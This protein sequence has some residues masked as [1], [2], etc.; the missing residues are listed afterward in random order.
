MRLTFGV[1]T[2]SCKHKDMNVAHLNHEQAIIFHVNLP[3]ENVRAE[4]NLT[5]GP[6]RRSPQ[7]T[8]TLHALATACAATGRLLTASTCRGG[9]LLAS[10]RAG[11]LAA[12]CG[13]AQVGCHDRIVAPVVLV[14][15]GV[16]LRRLVLI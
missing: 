13:L 7:G 11:A 5:S 8:E 1:L 16:D 9:L 10:T 2:I 6:S 14:R 12:S 15:R 3:V 4:I